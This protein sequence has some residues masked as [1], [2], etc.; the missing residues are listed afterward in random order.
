MRISRKNRVSFDRDFF[1]F[2]IKVKTTLAA[3]AQTKN[4]GK[5]PTDKL[6]FTPKSSCLTSLWGDFSRFDFSSTFSNE[7][8]VV[9]VEE[10][11]F[12]LWKYIKISVI[13]KEEEKYSV[14]NI[15]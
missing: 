2:H 3:A 9:D 6:H 4:K 7:E 1:R 10:L 8:I 15:N 12:L 5:M 11:F 14:G 13:M